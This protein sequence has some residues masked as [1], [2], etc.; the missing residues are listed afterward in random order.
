MS[1]RVFV[2]AN[3]LESLHANSD[4]APPALLHPLNGPVVACL[5][6]AEGVSGPPNATTGD[7]LAYWWT[8]ATLRI[9]RLETALANLVNSHGHAR[10]S[11]RMVTH[12]PPVPLFID[13][14]QPFPTERFSADSLYP[15]LLYTS[16]SP[17]DKRQS[18]M[19]SSA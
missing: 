3:T 16:P 5:I 12:Q 18:R 17:R 9:A 8:H 7:P 4:S 6:V 10:R 14:S 19:P 1:G 15:C 2:L 13:L 11:M